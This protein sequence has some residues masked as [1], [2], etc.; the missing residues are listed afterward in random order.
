MMKRL[1]AILATCFVVG[2]GTWFYRTHHGIAPS[3]TVAI[4]SDDGSGGGLSVPAINN[5]VSGD[6]GSSYSGNHLTSQY[7]GSYRV[8]SNSAG[9]LFVLAHYQIENSGTSKTVD[10]SF[11]VFNQKPERGKW[12][13]LDS[14]NATFAY[15]DGGTIRY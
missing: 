15:L 11:P 1:F 6:S 13:P 5:F 7:V 10:C 12:T 8:V 4:Q 2:A 9:K 14:H 3:I